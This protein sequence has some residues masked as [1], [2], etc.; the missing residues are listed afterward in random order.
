MQ[1]FTEMKDV[2][3]TYLENEIQEVA[4]RNTQDHFMKTLDATMQMKQ[5]E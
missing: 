5:A 1:M 3:K 4:D 2:H